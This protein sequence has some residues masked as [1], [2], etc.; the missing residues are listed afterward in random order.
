MFSRTNCDNI[1]SSDVFIE[2]EVVLIAQVVE[3]ITLELMAKC[4]PG[5]VAKVYFVLKNH[6]ILC[7]R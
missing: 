6:Q 4:F 7:S 5:I 1:N 2:S 3:L